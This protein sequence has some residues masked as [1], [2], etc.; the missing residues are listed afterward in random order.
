MSRRKLLILGRQIGLK[1]DLDEVQ[2][3]SLVPKPLARGK[4]TQRAS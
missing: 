2:V 1:M 4:Y 3:D